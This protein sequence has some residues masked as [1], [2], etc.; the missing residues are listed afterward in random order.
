MASIAN[1]ISPCQHITCGSICN[2]DAL[3]AHTRPIRIQEGVAVAVN[4]DAA[5]IGG[6][7]LAV[8]E[9]IGVGTKADVDAAEEAVGYAIEEGIVKGAE[10]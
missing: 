1:P 4:R 9:V 10:S 3:V 8:A 5:S 6:V 2:P 7:E